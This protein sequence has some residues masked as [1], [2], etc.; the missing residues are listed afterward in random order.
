MT[1]FLVALLLLTSVGCA[2]NSATQSK[3]R[4]V[5]VPGAGELSVLVTIE[6]TPLPG[7]LVGVWN[8]KTVCLSEETDATGRAHFSL[9]NGKYML[10][11][12]LPGLEPAIAKI[13]MP[14]DRAIEAVVSLVMQNLCGPTLIM[15]NREPL[16]VSEYV[17][18]QND[19]WP[20]PWPKKRPPS[21]LARRRVPE[22]PCVAALNDR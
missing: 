16:S 1:R 15:G 2:T 10:R 6:E 18:Y 20:T 19:A 17:L 4:V 14:R 12:Q 13:K 11:A 5:S 9:P 7:V 21:S 3:A 22:I 8:E